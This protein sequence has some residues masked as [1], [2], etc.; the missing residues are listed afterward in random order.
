MIG[1]SW[2]VS[3]IGP[4]WRDL[5]FYGTIIWNGLPPGAES[6]VALALLVAFYPRGT[7]SLIL[8]YSLS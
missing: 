2:W 1:I 4:C 8:K 3:I 6:A 7:A 5:L